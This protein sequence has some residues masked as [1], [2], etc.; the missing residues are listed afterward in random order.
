[1]FTLPD[2]E[3]PLDASCD[4]SGSALVHDFVDSLARLLLLVLLRGVAGTWSRLL[5]ARGN[6]IWK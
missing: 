1:M 5:P 2:P 3:L 6:S 4:P